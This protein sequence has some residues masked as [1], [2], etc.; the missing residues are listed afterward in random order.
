M[1][2]EYFE[3]N[4]EDKSFVVHLYQ[5]F[6]VPCANWMTSFVDS[7][8]GLPHASY[9]L[10]EEKFLTSTYTT[11]VVIAAL[12]TAAKL[13]TAFERPDE[14][15]KWS[16]A[17]DGIGSNLDKLYHPEGYFRKG[18]L[19]LD[20]GQ[21]QYDDT[22]DISNLYGPF[23]YAGLDLQDHRLLGTADRV[24]KA[25]LNTSPSGGVL[26]YEHDNYFLTRRNYKGNPWVVSTLWLAQYYATVGKRDQA[27]QLL[28]WSLAHELP[29]GAL[30]EQFDPETG[31][32]LV[33]TP[34]VWSHA[35]L[36][37]TLLDLSKTE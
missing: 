6:V 31:G 27:S 2:G 28:D 11:C 13:A 33:V 30:S 21:I 37:N 23:M 24:E 4:P 1:V 8:T 17:A 3:A 20:N 18:F 36:V 10:W 35:E 9:D 15:I 14:A 25:L 26:R 32:P 34:L 12:K 5:T 7:Q 29:S 16:K 19:L 22:V